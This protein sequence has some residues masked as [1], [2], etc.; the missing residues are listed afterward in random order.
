[1]GCLLCGCCG[2]C[3]FFFFKEETGYEM[4]ISDWSSDVCSS[5]LRMVPLPVPGRI[6]D[7]SSPTQ[8]RQTKS[9]PAPKHRWALYLRDAALFGARRDAVHQRV[10]FA[11]FPHLHHNVAAADEFALHIELRDR[12]PVG[13][14]L[15][16]L[17]DFHVLQPR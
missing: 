12:R 13:K 14:F 6:G 10:Q 15:D 7:G 9:P 16:A 5:D 2:S 3:V 4:R 11:R 1:M 17:T 8:S